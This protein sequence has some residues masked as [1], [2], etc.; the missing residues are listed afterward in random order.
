MSPLWKK[1]DEWSCNGNRWG[2]QKERGGICCDI[3][4]RRRC[5]TGRVWYHWRWKVASWRACEL[6][7]RCRSTAECPIDGSN[8]LQLS[9]VSGVR[10]IRL[11]F[12]IFSLFFFFDCVIKRCWRIFSSVFGIRGIRIRLVVEITIGCNRRFNFRKNVISL[13]VESSK[14]IHYILCSLAWH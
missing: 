13:N 4:G 7:S 11:I 5:R 14:E 12:W 9:F 8:C 1:R 2:V 6:G 10:S 3:L